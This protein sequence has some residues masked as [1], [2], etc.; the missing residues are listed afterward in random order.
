MDFAEA[1]ATPREGMDYDVVIVGAGPAGLAAAIRLKQLQPELAVVVVEKGSEVGAH[2]LSGAVIDPVGLD[3][4]LPD[5][6][7][8]EDRPLRTQVTDDRFYV[9]GPAGGLRL[10]NAFMP[11][12][13]GNHGNFI[14]SLG[15][16]CRYL[17]TQA[18]ALGVE[19]Y[20]GFAAAEMLYGDN[21]EVL[22]VATGDMGVSRSGEVKEGFTRGM[23]L[24][25][26]YTLLAE[27]AR[28]SLSKKVIARFGLDKDREPQKY[29]IGLKE[30][31]QVE[32]ARHQ[33]GLVQ[34]SFGWP[35]GNDTGGG[36]F[37][38]HFEDGLVSV[39]FV[40]HLNYANPYLSP[41][42]EFQRFK[43]HPLV[44]DTFV[45][46]KRLSY[47][48]RA[49]TEG[50]WQS[51][52]RLAFPGGALIGC[53]AGFVNVPRIKGSH[54]AVLSGMLAAEHVAAALE[55]GRAH[56]ELSGYEEA[57]RGSDIGRDMKPVRNAKPL[58]SKFGTAIG[59]PLG[60]LDMWLNE[61]LGFSPFGTLRH[62]KPDFATLKPAASSTPIAYPKPDGVVSFD[63][64]SSV[65]L[66]NTNHEEE[67]PVHLVLADP[68]IPIQ[69]NLPLYGEPARLYCP[70]GVYE[71]VYADAEA[72]T[73][74]RFQINA[75]NCVHCKT[76]DIKDPAQNIT[77]VPPEG[78]G[79]P[80]YPNM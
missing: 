11:R 27:G 68:S 60:G 16:V 48:A 80:N 38:Y 31:W 70:A 12:L 18:E 55:A 35:L 15:N 8:A 73:G 19:I 42:D 49:I 72:K 13:M 79:G 24:R 41:F 5:W 47:G 54:N 50:G 76:C 40:V 65:F 10:P 22:G 67:Q 57:W 30:L 2:I 74:P 37:L 77:W 4:L 34:H 78:G 14:G 58:W 62:G 28:G 61:T 20:P 52:P 36:S 3:R 1:L 51:V 17:A 71:V 44:R 63:K 21:G 75:Q 6:R 25:G 56:D 33:P 32:P 43:T 59:I 64:L 53:S 7:H 66:S 26:K 69:Q 29:G 9:L 23:E 45:G 46:G 39:G